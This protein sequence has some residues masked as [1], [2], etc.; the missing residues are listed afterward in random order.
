MI[1]FLKTGEIFTDFDLEQ[2]Y[3]LE[4]SKNKKIPQFEL[5]KKSFLDDNLY[6]SSALND[7]DLS[8]IYHQYGEIAAVKIYRISIHAPRAGCDSKRKQISRMIFLLFR[9]NNSISF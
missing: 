8:Q 4:K 6:V 3:E 5:W 9:N 2:R 1:Y 7:V